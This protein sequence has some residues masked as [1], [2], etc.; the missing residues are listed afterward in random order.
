MIKKNGNNT[1]LVILTQLNTIM[2]KQF[3]QLIYSLLIRYI[4]SYK[5]VL[6]VNIILEHFF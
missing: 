6:I 3:A 5:S 1:D 4:K 2:F